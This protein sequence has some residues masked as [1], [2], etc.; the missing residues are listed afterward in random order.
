M[1]AFERQGSSEDVAASQS[2]LILQ[3]CS[4]GIEKFALIFIIQL[5]HYKNIYTLYY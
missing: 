2:G 3:Y 4:Q 5:D 1:A